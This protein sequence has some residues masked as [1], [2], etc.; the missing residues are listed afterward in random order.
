[1]SGQQE[2]L[3]RALVGGMRSAPVRKVFMAMKQMRISTLI[4]GAALV[5]AW[6]MWRA[7]NSLDRF[8]VRTLQRTLHVKFSPQGI[9]S[10]AGV[11]EIVVQLASCREL[12]PDAYLRAIHALNSL[13]LLTTAIERGRI[14][15]AFEECAR[16]AALVSRVRRQ[17]LRMRAALWPHG[18]GAARLTDEQKSCALRLSRALVALSR[19][20]SPVL[21]AYYTRV[22]AACFQQNPDAEKAEEAQDSAEQANAAANSAPS[23]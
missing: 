4:G 22:Q 3:R 15:A 21:D 16:A 2:A 1:M 13:M 17:I 11:A 19:R 5:L 20:L 14:P 8:D 10:D 18:P 9:A 7:Y 23:S 6:E 12:D